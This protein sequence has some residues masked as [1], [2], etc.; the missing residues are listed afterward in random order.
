MRDLCFASATE[1]TRLYRARKVSPVE[2]MEAILGQVD[3]VNP[4]VNAI[5]TL[6][7]ESAQRAAR[8]ATRALSRKGELPPLFGVPVAIKDLTATRAIRT[9]LGSRIY[10]DHVPTEDALYVRRLRAAGAVMLGKTNTP[11]FGAG[12]RPSTRCSGPRATVTTSRGP[13]AG[14]AAGRPWPW[15][16]AWCP[17]PTGPTWA[18]AAQSRQLLQRGRVPAVSG[19]RS[20]RR[21]RA[22]V[23]A[24]LGG[25]PDGRTVADT[26]LLLSAWPDRTTLA[27]R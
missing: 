15:R 17:S 4:Q 1:L 27:I 14:A 9:T 25:R 24:A 2:A 12:R 19:P 7:R 3:R 20:Q 6:A 10:A 5:V 16:R 8:A 13:A 11:E 21:R 22:R 26:A 23:D 18:V